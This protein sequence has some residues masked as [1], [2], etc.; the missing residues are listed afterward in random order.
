LPY[1]GHSL[2]IVYDRTGA[3]Y[4]HGRGLMLFV[5]GKKVAGR[6]DLGPLEA[7]LPH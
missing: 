4:R 1:H 6:K 3:K 7:V 2:A 5:D